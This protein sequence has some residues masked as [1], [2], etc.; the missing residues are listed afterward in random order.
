MSEDTIPDY[1]PEL[2]G[3]VLAGF[4]GS[5]AP[6][7]LSPLYRAGIA[8]V[9]LGMVLL[10]LLYLAMLAAAVAG[11]WLYA[12]NVWPLLRGAGLWQGKL[13]LG[14]GPPLALLVVAFF[15]AKSI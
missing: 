4:S 10:P 5:I 1:G 14:G 8:V 6:V 9:A 15:L 7:S 3:E 12:A 2:A 13:I 11:A